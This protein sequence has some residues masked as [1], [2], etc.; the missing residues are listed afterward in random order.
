MNKLMYIHT[1]LIVRGGG[2][3]YTKLLV[4]KLTL[5]QSAIVMQNFASM[6]YVPQV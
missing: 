3:E 4:E 6:L 5:I 1:S 2:G